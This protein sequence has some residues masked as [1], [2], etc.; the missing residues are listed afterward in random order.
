[1]RPCPGR[2]VRVVG[3]AGAWCAGVISCVLRPRSVYGQGTGEIEDQCL[4]TV[5]KFSSFI[6]D[7]I[8]VTRGLPFSGRSSDLPV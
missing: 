8:M 1:M 7:I 4:Q 2:G 6:S 5:Q 3:R